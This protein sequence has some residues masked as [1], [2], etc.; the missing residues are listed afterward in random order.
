MSDI[1]HWI[2]V[3]A[4]PNRDAYPFLLAWEKRAVWGVENDG[5]RYAT[6][7]QAQRYAKRWGCKIPAIR[8]VQS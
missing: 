5:K 1:R 2:E 6:T 3:N 8:E 4:E 7:K